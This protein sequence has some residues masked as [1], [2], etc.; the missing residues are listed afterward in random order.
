MTINGIKQSFFY[1]IGI[2]ECSPDFVFS[3]RKLTNIRWMKHN[4]RDRFF[5]DPF[6][7]DVTEDE[8][9]ILVEECLFANM[10]SGMISE[11]RVS[12]KTMELIE[13]K[14][15]LRL[16]T[17]LS[18]PAILR[19]NGKIY[20]YPEN[21][22]SGKLYMYE[23]D[24]S[25]H[26]LIKPKLI[27][28]ESVAD[29]TIFKQG[30]KWFLIATKTPDTRKNAYIYSST[31]FDGIYSP[32]SD[33]PFAT[34]LESSRSGGDLINMNGVIYRPAQDCSERYGG[35]LSIMKFSLKQSS[36]EE[37]EECLAFKI[38]PLSWRYNLGIHTI[39]FYKNV[40]VI[41]SNG[42]LHP[43]VG[44]L[45]NM[46]IGNVYRILHWVHHLLLN[47]KIIAR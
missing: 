19:N 37:I 35:A 44:R 7:L 4:Y 3:N 13:K 5:A 22:A 36:T 38:K 46:S 24:K 33:K 29:A 14:E 39:N 28:D 27:L 11:L 23:F 30:E 31:T 45:Y 40:C 12:R 17:H 20:V 25:I 21:G 18:Y 34:S 6:I 9:Y 8:Y 2:V 43:F 15:V 10:H 16:D 32:V 42:Y 26:K 1:N 47:Q 41:D